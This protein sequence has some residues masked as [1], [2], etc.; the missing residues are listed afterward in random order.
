MKQFLM[1]AWLLVLAASA[2]AQDM[3]L[4]QILIDGEGWKP[5]KPSD[6]IPAPPPTV[7]KTGIVFYL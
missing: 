5:L 2:N 6:T 1:V 7:T 4:S 3:P